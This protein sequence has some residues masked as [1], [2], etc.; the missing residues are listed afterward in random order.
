MGIYKPTFRSGGLLQWIRGRGQQFGTSAHITKIGRN[1]LTVD[2]IGETA[3]Y[4]QM[5]SAEY[6]GWANMSFRAIIEYFIY[7]EAAYNTFG[8]IEYE[9]HEIIAKYFLGWR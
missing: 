3:H 5:I 2:I 6:G 9:A 8:T 4:Y 1:Y 7:G